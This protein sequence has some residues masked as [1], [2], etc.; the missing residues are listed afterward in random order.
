MREENKYIRRFTSAL[1]AATALYY[2][3]AFFAGTMTAIKLQAPILMVGLIVTFLTRPLSNRLPFKVVL[4]VDCLLAALSA[5]VLSYLIAVETE[6]EYFWVDPTGFIWFVATSVFL[7][8]MEATRR[9]LGWTLVGVV[10][11]F[12]LYA[13]YGNYMPDMIWHA[14]ITW[15]RIIYTVSLSIEG[16]WGIPLRVVAAIVV[17]FM[18]FSAFLRTTGAS[19]FL[20]DMSQS[21]FGKMRGGP[22]KMAVVA[23]S[24]FATMSGSGVANVTTTGV[25]TIPL[26]KRAGYPSHIAATIEA[27]SSTGGQ[28][29]PPIMGAAAF[30]MAEFI[31]VSYWAICVA[32]F[33]PAFLYY[34][35]LFLVVDFEAGKLHMKGLSPDEVT[36]W[37]KV[38]LRGWHILVPLIVLIVL[39]GGFAF[40]VATSVFYALVSLWVVSFFTKKTRLTPKKFYVGLETGIKDMTVVTIAVAAASLLMGLASATNLGMNL[41][42][43][44]IQISGGNLL[45]LLILSALVGLILGMGMSTSAI[46][47]FLAILIAPALV[48]M[49]VPIMA[50]HL[51]ILYFGVIHLITPPY[52]LASFV[53]AGIAGAPPMKVGWTAAFRGIILYILPFFFVYDQAL[54][55]QGSIADIVLALITSIIGVCGLVAAIEGYAFVGETKGILHRLLFGIGGVLMIHPALITDLAGV[56]LLAAAVVPVYMASRSRSIRE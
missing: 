53:A 39:L 36:D 12:M 3:Y 54:I 55:L 49:G 5:L 44:L 27:L 6:F 32:A 37:K 40:S 35:S 52:C 38:V 13:Y 25:I 16:V 7:L 45:I 43:V 26:M 33:L 34:V 17:L 46:Y 41:S 29:T 15:S 31:G 51:F 22:A 19:D 4:A 2:I 20:L 18:I 47:I 23:S 1:C 8:I 30:I 9:V 10:V 50:A 21:L 56:T 28:F 14:G 42:G 11:A 48:T 24:L